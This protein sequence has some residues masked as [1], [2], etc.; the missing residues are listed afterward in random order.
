MARLNLG[1]GI[2]GH[3]MVWLNKA[4]QFGTR[5]LRCLVR[6]R[7]SVVVIFQLQQMIWIGA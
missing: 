5:E 3:V 6:G 7:N 4:F 2:H 1:K